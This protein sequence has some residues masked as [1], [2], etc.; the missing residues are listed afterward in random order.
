[1]RRSSREGR[2]EF[3]G[4]ARPGSMRRGPEH[5][6]AK[7]S[8]RLSAVQADSAI[9]GRQRHCAELR[10]VISLSRNTDCSGRADGSKLPDRAPVQRSDPRLD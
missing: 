9:Q 1:M 3:G 7:R 2:S 8:G 4:G 10:W 6:S 5:C